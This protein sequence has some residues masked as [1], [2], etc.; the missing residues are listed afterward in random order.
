MSLKLFAAIIM[1]IH[2]VS[3]YRAVT[4]SINKPFM[5]QQPVQMILVH[6]IKF[7]HCAL[8]LCY[9]ACG[10][11]LENVVNMHFSASHTVMFF[12][13]YVMIIS[14]G[15]SH[16]ASSETQPYPCQNTTQA[17][18]I[19]NNLP[20]ERFVCTYFHT[21]RKFSSSLSECVMCTRTIS[22]NLSP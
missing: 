1:H 7:N 17:A 8:K 22:D 6:L 14:E 19:S 20:L 5:V 3:H 18:L 15:W 16:H 10:E 21:S 4:V 9:P 12:I 2:T 11:A 13:H